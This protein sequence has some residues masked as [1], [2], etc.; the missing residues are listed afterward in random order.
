[1]ATRG[2]TVV[3]AAVVTFAFS[4]TG[5]WS[6][7][8]VAVPFDVCAQSATWQRP[9]TD[10]QSTVWNNPRYG[11]LAVDQAYE[12]THSFFWSETDSAR[13][14]YDKVLLSG[15]WTE[16]PRGQCRYRGT[17][18]NQW[19]EIWALNHLVSGITIDGL[20]HTVTVVPQE[21]GYEV[22]QF[23]RPAAS[24]VRVRFVSGDGAVFTEWIETDPGMFSD[25]R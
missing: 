13:L 23:R 21:R 25:W 17:E 19:L 3:L 9:S 15:L 18:G 16:S 14:S 7:P 11:G 20:V 10:V 4:A 22:I 6:P 1:M 8:P 2:A 12:W 24:K 5:A